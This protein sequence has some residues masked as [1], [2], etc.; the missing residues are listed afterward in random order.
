MK[1]TKNFIRAVVVLAIALFASM[2]ISAMSPAQKLQQLKNRTQALEAQE[3][4]AQQNVIDKQQQAMNAIKQERS[5][6]IA[7]GKAISQQLPLVSSEEAAV[8]RQQLM[9]MK[10]RMVEIDDYIARMAGIR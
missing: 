6:L 8:L 7:Q 2:Q 1:N 10:R 5:Q 4:V 3:A 9:Q